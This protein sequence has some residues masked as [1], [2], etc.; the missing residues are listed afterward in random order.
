MLPR[1]NRLRR[2]RDIEK[3]LRRGRK[4]STT[5]F[6]VRVSPV[7]FGRLRATVVVGLAVA[8]RAVVRNR[9]KRQIRHQFKNLILGQGRP[10]D[11]MISARREALAKSAKARGQELEGVLKKSG[12]L[13]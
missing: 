12:V 7:S 9:L 2:Q 5:C 13:I 4:F 3:V 8:K 11:I 1:A 6:I 10:F